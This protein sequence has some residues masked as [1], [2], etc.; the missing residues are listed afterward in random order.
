[1]QNLWRQKS[2]NKRGIFSFSICNR[3]FFP[4]S[5]IIFFFTSICR[6]REP[7]IQK[8]EID[9]NDNIADRKMHSRS[10]S[11][12]TLKWTQI[13]SLI[14]GESPDW[15]LLLILIFSLNFHDVFI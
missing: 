13:S 9:E 3:Q 6:N 12:P 5:D 1:M 2:H 10:H 8:I 15:N 7:L 4:N 11:N 14:Q